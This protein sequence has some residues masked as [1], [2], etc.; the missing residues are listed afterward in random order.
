MHSFVRRLPFPLVQV[1]L[2][3]RLSALD[4][5]WFVPANPL[6]HQDG[7]EGNSMDAQ[8]SVEPGE[9]QHKVVRTVLD[10]DMQTL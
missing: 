2:V 3:I 10:P 8:A 9:S 1:R 7:A 6:G 4:P 5:K